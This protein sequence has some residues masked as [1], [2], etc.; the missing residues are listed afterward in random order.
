M[1]RLSV[2]IDPEQVEIIEVA[3][4]WTVTFEQPGFQAGGARSLLRVRIEELNL[5]SAGRKRP[6]LDSSPAGRVRPRPISNSLGQE[7]GHEQAM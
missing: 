1:L 6:E 2:P 7:G 3:L 4:A 5:N